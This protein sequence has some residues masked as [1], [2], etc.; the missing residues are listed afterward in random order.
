MLS[1][2]F[3]IMEGIRDSVNQLR[4]DLN[5]K[6]EDINNEIEFLGSVCWSIEND[7]KNLKN[8][9]ARSATSTPSMD[10]ARTTDKTLGRFPLQQTDD[11][12]L[13]EQQLE[14]SDVFENW[15]EYFAD[16][17]SNLRSSKTV[18]SRRKN[19][20]ELLFSE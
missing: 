18:Y 17:L 3:T 9:S 14:Q 12:L 10:S 7:L 5:Q 11:L 19:L 13:F 20:K 4:V 15:C 16:Q 1:G 8:Q 2:V 6:V